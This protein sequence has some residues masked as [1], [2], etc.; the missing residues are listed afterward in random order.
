MSLRPARL[1]AVL[2]VALCCAGDAL[3][4]DLPPPA[5]IRAARDRVFERPEFE[6]GTAPRVGESVLEMILRWF[7]EF[8]DWFS[9]AFPV[10][11]IVVL[12]SMLV[13]L[14]AIVAHLVWTWRVARRT[15]YQAE[16]PEDLAAALRRLDPRPFRERALSHAGAQRFDEAVR[17]LYTALLL[18]LDA[19]GAVRYARHKALL[20]YRIEAAGDPSARAVL[21]RFEDAYPPGSF[22]LRPPDAARFRELVAALDSVGPP[23]GG[24]P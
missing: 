21:A 20:D 10:L 22:G 7:R 14:V 6:Y 3:A 15:A 13:V 19:R 2:V 23:A 4:G 8:V 1:A 16:D 12:V 24:A 5:A 11:S 17:D 18:T 9:K